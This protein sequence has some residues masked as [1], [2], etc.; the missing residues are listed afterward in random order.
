MP[1]IAHRWARTI[2]LASPTEQCLQ[3]SS[4]CHGSV[5]FH[6]VDRPNSVYLFIVKEHLA[7]FYLLAVDAARTKCCAVFIP[8]RSGCGFL[9]PYILDSTCCQWFSF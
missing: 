8:A 9:P 4:V 7:S 3:G 2:G 6:H 1:D 5:I